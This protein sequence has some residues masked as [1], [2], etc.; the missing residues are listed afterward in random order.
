MSER[1]EFVILH[2]ADRDNSIPVIAR[3][4]RDGESLKAKLPHSRA[5]G[6]PE[7]LELA[8]SDLELLREHAP[9]R[10]AFYYS[11]RLFPEEA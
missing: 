1:W 6:L 2:F 10:P 4:V 8:E 3:L 9:G 5:A 11:R 7:T